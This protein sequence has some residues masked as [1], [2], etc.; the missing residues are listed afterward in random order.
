MGFQVSAGVNVSEID[1]DVWL[2]SKAHP[3]I[4]AGDDGEQRQRSRHHRVS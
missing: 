3:A 2:Q 1:L 4:R